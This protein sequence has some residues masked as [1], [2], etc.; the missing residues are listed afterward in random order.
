VASNVEAETGR[1]ARLAL[2]LNVLVGGAGA[3]GNRLYE[4]S[5]VQLC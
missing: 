5:H 3:C 1:V 4:Q 2:P